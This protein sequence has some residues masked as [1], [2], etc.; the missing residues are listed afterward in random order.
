MSILVKNL[1]NS[2]D[3]RLLLVFCLTIF[4]QTLF[5]QNRQVE[6]PQ[7]IVKLQEDV[8]PKVFFEKFFTKHRLDQVQYLKTFSKKYDLSLLEF[9][10]V[11]HN[12]NSL[13]RLL[14]KESEVLFAVQNIRA[15]IY[16]TPDDPDYGEQWSYNLINAPEVWDFTT[17]GLTPLGD[18]IVI[19][20]MEACDTRHEDLKA[21]IWRNY[22]EIPNNG[23]DDDGNGYV[24]DYEGYNSRSNN[25][26]HVSSSHGTRVCGIIG[27]RGNNSIGVTGV[28]WNTQ[29]MVVSNDLY[30]DEIVV[31]YEYVLK[32]R[33]D[34]NNTNG[35]KGAFVVATNA[36][37][38][39]DNRFPDANPL[40]LTWCDLI[41]DLGEVGVLSVVATNND[42]I[43]LD[44]IGDVPS[45]CPTNYL[46]AVTNTD[47]AD[48]LHGA[49]SKTHIDL[50]APGRGSFSTRPNNEY[51]QIGGTSAATP[52]VT[53]SIGLLYS[54]PC[55]Q[56]A[57]LA[58]NNP[59][60]AASSMKQFILEGVTPIATLSDKTVT[61]GRLNL[62]SS[63]NI[64]QEYCD[65][66]AVPL[67]ISSITPSP[68]VPGNTLTIKFR[69]PDEKV[70]RYFVSDAMGRVILRDEKQATT[71][72]ANIIEI[73][74]LHMT[75][76]VYFIT[77][78]NNQDIESRSFLV[79]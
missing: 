49:Y 68:V 62:E 23:I 36:S 61:G 46:I 42:N 31:A 74:T 26:S 55:E 79:Y 45:F 9:H 44:T 41:Q 13:I 16:Q 28:N 22:A 11:H 65:G 5:A 63:L 32:Q 67:E 10:P 58:K 1:K 59:A 7:L 14:E 78:E 19:A 66:G 25:D 64:L 38:G 35:A 77:I 53:G 4:V 24:D 69:T 71:F 21:N 48:E 15:T 51:G 33:T 52:H 8:A 50:A 60:A 3:M 70:Y 76:G 37:F 17:G 54:A 40:F 27:A 73:N 2:G 56:F 39:F 29:M 57:S 18:T 43:E 47:Q 72:G 75:S 6:I 12:S 20:T 30:I 34:Y